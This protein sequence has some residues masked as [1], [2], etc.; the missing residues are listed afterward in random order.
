MGCRIKRA[1]VLLG[2]LPALLLTGCAPAPQ[3][4]EN[5]GYRLVFADQFDEYDPFVWATAPF[6]GSLQ[7][8]VSDGV[9]T[10]RTTAAN[11]YQWGHVASTG[12]RRSEA[13]PNYPFARAWQRGYFEAR[14][15]YSRSPWSWPAFWLFSQDKTERWPETCPP[16]SLL[17]SEWDI[18]DNGTWDGTPSAQNLYHGALHRNTV[19]GTIPHCGIADTQQRYTVRGPSTLDLSGWHTWSGRWTDTELCS[20]IDGLPIWCATP[21]DSTEQ[22]MNIVF[23]MQF[24]NCTIPELCGQRPSELWM[25]VDWV[26]V[27]QQ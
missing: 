23:T 3:P 5:A 22:P 12:P 11:G 14:V 8:T 7:P 15:R 1:C 24:G 10:I 4:I 2:G 9:M 19:A 13:E 25:E 20:Y 26:R 6:G 21:Y 27:W 18:F 17:I 16:G